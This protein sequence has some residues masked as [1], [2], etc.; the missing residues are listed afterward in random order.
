MI[1]AYKICA[2]CAVLLSSI[3]VASV[4]RPDWNFAVAYSFAGALLIFAASR[5]QLR[6]ALYAV[7]T[8]VLIAAPLV[9]R[10]CSLTPLNIAAF[11]GI[12]C[13]AVMALN[14][15]WTE[16]ASYKRPLGHALIMPV[17]AMIG[18]LFVDHVLG[19]AQYSYDY[20]LYAF[21]VRLGLTP[22]QTV[23]GL[24]QALPW[25]ANASRFTYDN[26][27][28][29]PLLFHAWALYRGVS[30]PH[31]AHAFVLAGVC[32][33]FLY[34]VCP[35]IGPY[36]WFGRDFPNLPAVATLNATPFLS[37]SIHNA[38]PSLHFTWALLVLW[39]ARELG[40]WAVGLAVAF[41]SL[42]GLATVGFGEHYF[43]DLV[44]AVPLA[45]WVESA[46]KKS[47]VPAIAGLALVF[48]W[49]GFLRLGAGL[50]MHRL[51]LW[52]L[53]LWTC[54]TTGYLM[55]FTLSKS[56]PK[57]ALVLKKTWTRPNENLPSGRSLCI[58]DRSHERG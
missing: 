16:S 9:V 50:T 14:I 24:F 25:L 31:Q 38:M 28:L 52:G 47:W 29:F 51:A 34:W 11:L 27:L 57:I 19:R 8:S 45:M 48:G 36:Y 10:Q 23:S 6:H 26:L 43:I 53:V 13:V 41:V 39:T 5:P 3:L 20:Y 55:I 54:V 12:G 58:G 35:A 4:F 1:K 22:G 2:S 37:A 33:W 56:S 32:G 21:D 15:I 42:T 44:V 46:L 7:L 18:G 17:F 30:R 49:L 40:P